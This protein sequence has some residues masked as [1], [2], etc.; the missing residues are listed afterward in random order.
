MCFQDAGW[1]PVKTRF[2][3]DLHLKSQIGLV[4]PMKSRIRYGPSTKP[5]FFSISPSPEKHVNANIHG[6][7]KLT[8]TLGGR[9]NMKGS[10]SNP[11]FSGAIN[12]VS[13]R[14][15]FQG[16][17]YPVILLGFLYK[18]RNKDPGT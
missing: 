18:P 9:L 8:C 12:V 13:G 14:V 17:H 6:T 7:L 3:N 5:C 15:V 11:H 1:V 2:R 4:T 10:S 16:L